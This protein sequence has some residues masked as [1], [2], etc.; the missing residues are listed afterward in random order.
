MKSAT[1]QAVTRR[2][3]G[4]QDRFRRPLT[5]CVMFP[6]R[7]LFLGFEPKLPTKYNARPFVSIAQI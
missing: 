1:Y 4:M 3:G 6:P 5:S 7:Y 2:A